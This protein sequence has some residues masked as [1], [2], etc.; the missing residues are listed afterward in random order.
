MYYAKLH[1]LWH[2][3][4][5]STWE[6]TFCM[7]VRNE[8]KIQLYYFGFVISQAEEHENVKKYMFM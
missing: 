7:R 2:F 3:N 8:N 4:T 1:K 6:H 5:T